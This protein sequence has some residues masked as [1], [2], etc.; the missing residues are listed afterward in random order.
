MGPYLHQSTF[1][2]CACPLIKKKYFKF[3]V[4]VC[5]VC[6]MCGCS[7]DIRKRCQIYQGLELRVVPMWVLGFELWSSGIAASTLSHGATSQLNYTSSFY[8]VLWEKLQ[9]GYPCFFG[10]PEQPGKVDKEVSLIC[11]RMRKWR[12]KIAKWC[13]QMP[14]VD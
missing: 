14:L 1:Q 2:R 5:G 8:L 3:G 9:V 11:V 10:N 7:N 13:A 6:H 4:E 12:F